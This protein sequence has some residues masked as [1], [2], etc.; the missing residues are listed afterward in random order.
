M[1]FHNNDA[2][3]VIYY[4]YD[5]S[6]LTRTYIHNSGITIAIAHKFLG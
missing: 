2:R 4:Y 1:I 3:G 5:V 6:N